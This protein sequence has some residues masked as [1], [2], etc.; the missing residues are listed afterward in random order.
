MSSLNYQNTQTHFN[1]GCDFLVA[2]KRFKD[3]L[4]LQ[5]VDSKRVFKAVIKDFI[6]G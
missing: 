1:L 4:I 3:I 6:D 2:S 5:D